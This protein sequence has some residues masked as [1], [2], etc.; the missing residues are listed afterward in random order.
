MFAFVVLGYSVLK[1]PPTPLNILRCA[2]NNS[3]EVRMSRIDQDV[4]FVASSDCAGNLE[5]S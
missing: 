3:F 4:V 5:N 1:Q 2:C